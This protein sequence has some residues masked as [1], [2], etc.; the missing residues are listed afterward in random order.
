MSRDLE[1]DIEPEATVMR[2]AM[3]AWV[4][5]AMS[6]ITR[7]DIPDMLEEHGPSTA[8]DLVGKLG[9]PARADLL[10][11]TLRA[12]ASAGLVSEDA[13]GRFGPTALTR[14]L[15]EKSPRSMKHLIEVMGASW[16]RLWGE[17]EP[18][19]RTGESGPERL[20]GMSYWDYCQSEP[21]EMEDFGAAMR[22]TSR[23]SLP[24]ILEHS[25]LSRAGRVA[26]IAG[27]LGHVAI[28]F[29]RHYEDLE[30]VVLDLPELSAM[31][32]R[33]AE[34]IEAGVRERLT[35]L[36]GDMFES[37]PPADVYFLKHIIHDW[38]DEEC[39]RILSNCRSAMLGEGKLLC[40]D[41]V[42]PPMGDTSGF[43]GKFFDVDMI[44]F[45]MGKER[46]E[47]EWRTLFRD[48]GFAVVSITPLNDDFGT[49]LIEGR[50]V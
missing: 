46:T 22:S 49:S 37:V 41:V 39:K 4:S 5:Q 45:A 8:E 25:D 15:T 36:P 35:F 32:Q 34:T 27:G 9:V 30:A 3:G 43:S 23:R 11:R 1:S 38:H 7:L 18:I 20:F 48:S 16:W 24:G 28:A 17:L 33:E 14:V 44:A 47:E 21:K 19:V 26:D 6:A 50:P 2:L 10:Q 29:L 13:E 31:A 42:L 40:V 12:C